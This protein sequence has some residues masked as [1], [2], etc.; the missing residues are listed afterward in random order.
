MDKRLR[1]LL[2]GHIERHPAIQARDIYKLLFQGV[3]GVGHLI[4]E[5]TWD[6]LREEAGRIN[7][8]DHPEEPLVEEVS[9]DGSMIRVNLRPYLRAGHSLES[10]Y[11]A[12]KESATH[13]GDEAVF[14][15]YWEP[16]KQLVTEQGLPFIVESIEKLD[17][18]MAEE[19]VKPKHHTQKYRDAYYPAYRVVKLDIYQ[20]LCLS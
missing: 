5:K 4:S 16:F 11:Q 13:E 18:S 9:P 10:L 20:R 6:S 17:E 7:I 1:E 12:M 15:G 14:L 2:L 19:G 8:D 3:F